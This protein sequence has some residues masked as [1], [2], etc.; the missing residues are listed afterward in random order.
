MKRPRRAL[1]VLTLGALLIYLLALLSVVQVSREDQR[2]PVYAIVVLGAAHYNGRPSP[3]LRARLDHAHALYAAGYATRIVVTG[4][5]ARGDTVSEAVVGQR[6][7]QSLGVPDDMIVALPAGH[8]TQASIADVADWLQRQGQASV[9]LVSDPFHMCR[10]RLEARGAGLV[11]FTSPTPDSPIARGS[12]QEWLYFAA[13]AFKVP[14]AWV[15][16]MI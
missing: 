16:A 1:G 3:V 14:V 2:R 10:L 15:R 4:A 9:L 13:E 5:T 12:R 11:A 8:S 6:Y 7:L